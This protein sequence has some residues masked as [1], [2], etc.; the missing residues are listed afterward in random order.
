ARVQRGDGF[1]SAHLDWLLDWETE[2]RKPGATDFL[3]GLRPMIA[4]NAQLHVLHRLHEGQFAPERYGIEIH[5]PFVTDLRCAKWTVAL[6]ASCEGRRTWCE[7][8]ADSRRAGFIGNE[9]PD[10]EFADLLRALVGQGLLRVTERP[11]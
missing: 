9:V 4:P 1:R 7:V 10:N 2:C 5:E 11:L 3:F 8:L 6:I